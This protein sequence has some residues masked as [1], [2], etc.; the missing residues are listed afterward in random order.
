MRTLLTPT[1]LGLAFGLAA[2]AQPPGDERVAQTNPS[3]KDEIVLS[4]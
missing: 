2:S 1:L 4:F 3:R